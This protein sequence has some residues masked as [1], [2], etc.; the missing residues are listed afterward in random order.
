[1]PAPPPPAM[2]LD[3]DILEL[4]NSFRQQ[5]ALPPLM[6]HK[7]L[8][9]V[10]AKHAADVADGA[11]PFSHA[12][13]PERFSSCQGARWVNVAENLARSDGFGRD[14]LPQATVSGWC[15]SPGHRR[16]LLGPF[17][18]CGIGW[19]ASDAGTIFVTQL[20]ALRDARDCP[21]V[22][23]QT[24][25]V[26]CEGAIRVANSAPAV[27][28]ALG[29]ALSGPAVAL[30]AGALGGALGHGYGLKATSVP[31]WG[32]GK[33]WRWLRPA[34]C[35]R[36]GGGGGSLALAADGALLCVDC[37]PAPGDQANWNYVE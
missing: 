32:C 20:L 2:P 4:T 11:A 13:A 27:C 21:T 9:R 31:L 34:C 26:L 7:A 25:Q 23:A 33:A 35:S 18:A 29:L 3:E 22:Y 36:C 5:H 24:S 19:A 30:G 28:A 37:H 16:N 10:A 1:M 12:G 6:H 15:G 17:D 14:E 8:A